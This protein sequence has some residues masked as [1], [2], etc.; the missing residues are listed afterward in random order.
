MAG[1][2]LCKCS[3]PSRTSERSVLSADH[4]APQRDVANPAEYTRIIQ[5]Q[6]THNNQEPI[7][8]S[9]LLPFLVN[10]RLRLY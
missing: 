4:R 3:G 6:Y 10:L 5:V 7:V 2:S 8:I 9:S 1:Q